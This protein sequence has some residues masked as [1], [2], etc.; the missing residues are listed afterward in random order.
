VIVEA[1]GRL[2]HAV[3]EARV[4]LFT[5]AAGQRF[6]GAPG[7]E[8]HAAVSHREL[9]ERLPSFDAALCLYR[10]IPGSAAGFYNSPLKLFD[11]L[12]AGLPVIGSRLGQIAHVLADGAG[13][14]VDDDPTE[15]AEALIDLAGDPERRRSLG[16]AGLERLRARY[17]WDHCGDRLQAVLSSVIRPPLGY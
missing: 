10:P 12:A 13:L 2:A 17:T 3:P 5:D 11:Y 14:L 1:A 4:H 6:A 15:V 7:V 8:L 16:A 9:A